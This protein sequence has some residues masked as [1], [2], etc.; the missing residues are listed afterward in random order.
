[1][2]RLAQFAFAV[3]LGVVTEISVDFLKCMARSIWFGD[4]HPRIIDLPGLIGGICLFIFILVLSVMAPEW[5]VRREAK[6]DG[7]KTVDPPEK[8]T[9]EKITE[10]KITAGDRFLL[11]SAFIVAICITGIRYPSIC[12]QPQIKDPTSNAIMKHVRTLPIVAEEA[13]RRG[14]L[15]DS[16][17][18]TR[19]GTPLQHRADPAHP[20]H[21]PEP[22]G[23]ATRDV[24]DAM[25]THSLMGE[26]R[27]RP[28]DD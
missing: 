12:D 17:R 16:V 20:S 10:E 23:T 7:D 4:V 18:R 8:V 3:F 2:R 26:G 1:M 21:P 13:D 28:A 14:I 15:R 5:I 22:E 24:A 25:G 19:L 11:I 9:A 6:I 27:L